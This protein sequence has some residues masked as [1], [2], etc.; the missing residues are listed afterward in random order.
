MGCENCPDKSALDNPAGVLYVVYTGGPPHAPFAAMRAAVP[1]DGIIRRYRPA[2]HPDGR[3]EYERDVPA[4]PAPEGYQ[5]DASDP[6]TL[7]PTW[8]S[9]V[10]RS[11]RVQLLDDGILNVEGQCLNPRSG[12]KGYEIVTR[13]FCR[14]CPVGCA[15]GQPPEAIGRTDWSPSPADPPGPITGR[16]KPG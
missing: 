4:P 15:I 5:A 7:R 12:K 16:A 10:F 8:V 3:I 14:L 11:Y 9:C 13:D 1:N 2:V 6:W